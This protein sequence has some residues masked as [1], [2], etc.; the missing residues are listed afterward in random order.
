MHVLFVIRDMGKL[1]LSELGFWCDFRFKQEPPPPWSA[2]TASL[3]VAVIVLLVGHIFH[4]AINR[5]EKV[6]D[7]YHEMKELKVRAE[8]AD[9]AKSQ[10]CFFI[11]PFWYYGE[12]DF[13][14]LF[15]YF[16]EAYGFFICEV[17][18]T[19]MFGYSSFLSVEVDT[20]IF[21]IT[22]PGNCF[23]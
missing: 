22:V 14:H 13:T 15:L 23:S 20:S 5:I 4:A 19:C 17:S 11:T 21:S 7:D 8:A 16:I 2:I 10:V 6:E 12:D 1:A 9:V 3:G 18:F